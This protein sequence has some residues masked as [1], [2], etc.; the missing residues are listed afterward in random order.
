MQRT[1]IGAIL[2]AVTALSLGG[3]FESADEKEAKI[4]EQKSK[5]FWDM[6]GPTDRSKSEGFKP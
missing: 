1:I 2:V 6:G 5:D 3:C 4:A